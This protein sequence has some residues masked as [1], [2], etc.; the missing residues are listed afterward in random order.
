MTVPIYVRFHGRETK[1]EPRYARARPQSLDSIEHCRAHDP[2]TDTPSP[3]STFDRRHTFSPP[4]PLCGISGRRRD[5]LLA[6]S[7]PT[8][9]DGSRRTD[10]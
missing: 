4:S 2:S 1:T 3:L 9:D 5:N 8:D 10:R 7:G 6:A